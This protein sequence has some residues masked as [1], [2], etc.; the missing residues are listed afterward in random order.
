M[1][2]SWCQTAEFSKDSPWLLR[3]FDQ[4]RFYPVSHEELM[5]WREDFP[6]GRASLQIE[7][8]RFSLR[9]YNTFL[10]READSIQCFKQHQQASFDAERERWAAAGQDLVSVEEVAAVNEDTV[11]GVGEHAISSSVPGSLWQLPVQI[12]ERVSAGDTVA[13]IESMKMEIPVQAHVS[14]EVI[15]LLCEPGT[16]LAPGQVLLVI[17]EDGA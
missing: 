15:R 13:V 11:L 5:Q 10:Q 9:E 7:E 16:S 3:F 17:R 6:R 12:G 2:N 8:T 4:L 14:G 1:W